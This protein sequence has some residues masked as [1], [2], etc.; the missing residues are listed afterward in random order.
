[1]AETINLDN[2]T[3]TTQYHRFS[4]IRSFPVATDGAI[5]LA[6]SENCFWLLDAIASHQGNEKLDPEFQVWE[7]KVNQ[8]DKDAVLRGYND[9]VLIVEQKIPYTDFSRSGIKLYLIQNVILLPS[10]Y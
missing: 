1:M 2:Y 5:A 4:T 8:I 9:N 10:E 7:L 3:G 6:E